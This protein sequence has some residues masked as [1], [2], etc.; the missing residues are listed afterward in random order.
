MTRGRWWLL[1]GAFGAP[2]VFAETVYVTDQLTTPLRAD[3]GAEATVVKTVPTGTALE[4]IERNGDVVHVRDP[5]GTEGWIKASVLTAQPPAGTQLKAVRTELDRTRAQLVQTQAE[6]DK[7]RAAPAPSV[8]DEAPQ[9]EIAALRVQLEQAQAELKKKEVPAVTASA[10][11]DGGTTPIDSG[12]FNWVWLGIAFAML[13][14]GFVGGI[15]WVRESIR[16]R[17]GGLYLRI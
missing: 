4:L 3:P 17:M 8:G 15:V 14:L 12:G 16:R 7:R 6:L 10:A 5:Q 1:I 11:S 9:A 2:L 13:L